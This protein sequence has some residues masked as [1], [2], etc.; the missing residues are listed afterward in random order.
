MK[1]NIFLQKR[2][3]WSL[4]GG[5]WDGERHEELELG[6]VPLPVDEEYL[7]NWSRSGQIMVNLPFMDAYFLLPSQWSLVLISSNPPRNKAL[8]LIIVHLVQATEESLESCPE[9]PITRLESSRCWQGGESLTPNPSLR[10][11]IRQ[12]PLW[13]GLKTL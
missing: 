9:G 8:S 11:R 12:S 6:P 1:W 4:S 2:E 10:F 7:T 13:D 3:V 5:K